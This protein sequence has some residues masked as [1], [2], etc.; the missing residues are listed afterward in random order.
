MKSQSFRRF[1]TKICIAGSMALLAIPVT[2]TAKKSDA[3]LKNKKAYSR[4]LGR[5]KDVVVHIRDFGGVGDGVTNNTAAF[6]KASAYLQTNG[7][8]LIIDPGMYIVGKQ[9]FTGSYT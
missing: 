1:T 4:Q 9:R 8:T 3:L 7:G 6:Q 5:S 2:S